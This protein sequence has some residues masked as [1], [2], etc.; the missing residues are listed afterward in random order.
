LQLD[1][2]Q[3]H[4]APLWGHQGFAYGAVNGVFF[5][6]QGNGFAALNSG[7]GERRYGHLAAVNRGLIDA[8]LP[9]GE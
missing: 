4:P 7:S 2:P 9:K 1:D 5:D 8:L 6:A 3:V